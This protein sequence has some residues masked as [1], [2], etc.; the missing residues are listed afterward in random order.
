MQNAEE[1][2]VMETWGSGL[3]VESSPAG[4]REG[5]TVSGLRAKI[6]EGTV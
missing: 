2:G 5:A 3:E 1:G 6:T 4:S